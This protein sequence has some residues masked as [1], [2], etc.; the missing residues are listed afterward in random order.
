MI[1]VN[2]VYTIIDGFTSESNAVMTLIDSVYSQPDGNVLSSAMA[3]MYFLVVI[4]ILA[5][6]AAIMSAFVFYQRRD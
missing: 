6:V 1:L 2:V 5:A 4:L 3:W